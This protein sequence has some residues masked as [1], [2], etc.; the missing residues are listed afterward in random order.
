MMPATGYDHS[1]ITV[2]SRVE[3]HPACDLWMRG[4]RFGTVTGI[5][6]VRNE[7][8]NLRTDVTV[9]LDKMPN[10]K[11]RVSPDNLRAVAGGA[12]SHSLRSQADC[13]EPQS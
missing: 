12:L 2:G 9:Q 7:F 11:L 6:R 4:A 10:R 8:R 1:E 13:Q 3:L 5:R